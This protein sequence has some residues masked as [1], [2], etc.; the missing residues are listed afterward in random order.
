MSAKP[1]NKVAVGA[2]AGAIVAVLAW[3]SKAFAHVEIPAEV[4]VSLSAII[5]FGVQYFVPD[6]QDSA[7]VGTTP[8]DSP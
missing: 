7:D 8:K 1:T 3:A 2:L 4:G 6:A 5:T